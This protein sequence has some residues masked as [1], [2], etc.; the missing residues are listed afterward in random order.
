[1]DMVVL[2]LARN[3]ASPLR[4][5]TLDGRKYLVAPAIMMTEGVW[6]SLYYPA[7]ELKKSV[8]AWN[9]RP[10]CVGHPSTIDGSK[11]SATSSPTT[12]SE[13]GIG[14]LFNTSWDE[15]GKKLKTEAWIDLDKTAMNEKGK[16]VVSGIREG[17][18]IDVSTGLFIDVVANEGVFNGAE[19]KGV[20]TNH[21]PDHLA[22]LP[23][24]KGACSTADGA[25]IPR[26]NEQEEDMPG[27]IWKMLTKVVSRLVG[28]RDSSLDDRRRQLRSALEK[29]HP[30]GGYLYVEDMR[31]ESVIYMLEQSKGPNKL[32]KMSYSVND[33]GVVSLGS[34]T[35]EEVVLVTDYVPVT[36]EKK[37]EK[38]AETMDKAA[39]IAKL[40]ENGWTADDK[41]TLETLSEKQL[42][43]ML[44]KTEEPKKEEPKKEEPKTP[45]TNAAEPDKE[46]PKK[47]VTAEEFLAAAPESVREVLQSG[48]AMHEDQKSKLVAGLKANTRCEYTE[49]EL[50]GM[51]LQQLQRLAKLAQVEVSFAGNDITPA[52]EANASAQKA[53]PMPVWDYENDCIKGQEPKPKKA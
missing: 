9:G 44:P 22:A 17:K 37:D 16:S 24:A 13:N 8:A 20:A 5:E 19:Y 47:S 23:N 14:M 11:V 12:L 25:G 35:P 10:V 2:Q 4:E 31:E 45:K 36:N 3:E 52:P 26:V 7:S 6:N 1:M 15:E 39:M 42:E 49:E 18:M 43:R 53:M 28:N 46:E 51:N 32:L 38:G 50:K 34:E 33:E 48:L 27:G 29:K 41:S 40:M 21:R 30:G